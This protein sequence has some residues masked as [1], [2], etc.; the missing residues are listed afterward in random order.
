MWRALVTSYHNVNSYEE[1]G[2]SLLIA[3]SCPL[4]LRIIVFHSWFR[5]PKA[6]PT[7]VGG[8][9]PCPCPCPCP[10]PGPGPGPG[11]CKARTEVVRKVRPREAG[12]KDEDPCNEH[13][14]VP[15][16]GQ[17]GVADRCSPAGRCVC[18]EYAIVTHQAE[19]GERTGEPAC[20]ASGM[21]WSGR[22]MPSWTPQRTG[23]DHDRADG[24][25]RGPAFL[26]RGFRPCTH[27]RACA[28]PAHRHSDDGGEPACWG[29]QTHEGLANQGTLRLTLGS[30]PVTATFATHLLLPSWSLLR[31]SSDSCR[32]LPPPPP[33]PPPPPLSW[34]PPGASRPCSR[35]LLSP[36]AA[37]GGASNRVRRRLLLPWPGADDRSRSSRRASSRLYPPPPPPLVETKPFPL[38]LPRGWVFG[39]LPPSPP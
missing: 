27:A 18:T 1:L 4:R 26:C 9:C 29:G 37:S 22:P 2:R 11:P 31:R 33:V 23:H 20:L 6:H 21:R 39:L 24:R 8:P 35:L 15:L 3:V 5:H 10:G 7:I 13:V 36:P 12:S 34:R 38:P 19:K 25:G 30:C 14:E 28:R 17:R 16:G 32:L